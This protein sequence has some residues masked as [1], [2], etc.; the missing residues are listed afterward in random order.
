MQLVNSDTTSDQRRPTPCMKLAD[1]PLI[2]GVFQ[3][4]LLLALGSCRDW[5]VHRF[6]ETVAK[7]GR[8]PRHIFSPSSLNFINASALPRA[9]STG[10]CVC[11]V[12]RYF[13]H[14]VA[15]YAS[16]TRPA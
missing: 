12:T 5:I 3:P 7:E 6:G 4:A 1:G 14:S 10:L 16:L 8:L 2:V 13:F 15:L 11:C 9:S